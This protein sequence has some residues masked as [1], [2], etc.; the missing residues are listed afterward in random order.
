M[1]MALE[2]GA[3]DFARGVLENFYVRTERFLC[4]SFSVSMSSWKTIICQDRLE[5][6]ALK[7]EKGRARTHSATIF[8]RMVRVFVSKTSTH[9]SMS[10]CFSFCLTLISSTTR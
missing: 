8:A 2:I 7:G 3:F 5:T 4:L 1:G 6:K 9:Q 10:P